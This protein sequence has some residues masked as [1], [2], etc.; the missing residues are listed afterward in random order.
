MGKIIFT[1]LLL[2]HLYLMHGTS[3]Y[4]GLDVH[5]VGLYGNLEP[6]QVITVK[7]GICVKVGSPCNEKLWDIGVRIEDDILI[8]EEDHLIL[9]DCVPRTV[10]EIEALMEQESY[11]DK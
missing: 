3:H 2:F 11:L 4:L 7:P 9:S 5:Y 8:T 10:E 1:F 6:N